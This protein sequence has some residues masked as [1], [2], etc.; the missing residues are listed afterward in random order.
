MRSIGFTLIIMLGLAIQLAASM[1][2]AAQ[3]AQTRPWSI[4]ADHGGQVVDYARRVSIARHSKRNVRIEGAC[5]S[6]CTL[7][8]SLPNSQICLA[9]GAFFGF[10]RAYGASQ[11][12]NEWATGYMMRKYPTWV[13]LWLLSKGGLTHRVKRMDYAYA[14]QFMPACRAS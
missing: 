7:F 3:V 6:A 13:R 12:S 5:Q 11:A 9:P 10:H 8:L 1:P 14:S 2:A 4:R